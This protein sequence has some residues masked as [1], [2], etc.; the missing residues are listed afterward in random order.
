MNQRKLPY[1]AL[2]GGFRAKVK[3]LLNAVLK[4]AGLEIDSTLRQQI[5]NAR[6]QKLTTRGHWTDPKYTQALKID[7]KTALDFLEETC[8]EYRT[9]YQTFPISQNGDSGQFFLQN[10][11]FDA[12]DAEVL[13]S[14]LRRFHP[15]NI[16]E[17][18]SG[19]STRVMRRAIRDGKLVTK[20]TS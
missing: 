14:V 2:P 16:V 11:W 17:V 1:E 5:E 18:G 6:L 10:G 4:P 12:V 15:T 13:Y 3:T 8:G 19:F 20:I 9:D 7:R